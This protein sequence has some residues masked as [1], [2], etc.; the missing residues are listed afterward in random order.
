MALYDREGKILLM[1]KSGAANLGG[2]PENFVGKSIL[3]LFPKTGN[4]YLERINKAFRTSSSEEYEDEV[5]FPPGKRW[6]ASV[7]QPVAGLDDEIFA[8]LIMSVDITPRKKAK[9]ALWESEE[10]YRDLYYE[11]PM[12]Y[13]ELDRDG[14]ITKVNRRELEMLGYNAEELI[15]QPVWKFVVEED[16]QESIMGKITDES[17]VS[18]GRD[19]N[20]RRKDGTTLPVLVDDR[21]VRDSDGRITGI[22]STIQDITELKQAEKAQRES[23]KKYRLFVE[24]ANDAIFVVQDGRTPFANQRSEDLLGYTLDELKEV[25]I[26]EW[27]HPADREMALDR[28]RRKLKGEDPPTDYTFR[29]IRRGSETRWVL[30]NCVLIE[31][32]ERPA[33][34]TFMRDITEQKQVEVQLQQAQKM[35]ALGAM[36][37]GLAHEINNPVNCI[38][39]NAPLIERIWEDILP[40]VQDYAEKNSEKTYG[41]LTFLFL[42]ENFAQ[43]ISDMGLAG[44]RI[45]KLVAALKN[46]VRQP[47]EI[48]KE[49]VDIN[50]VVENALQLS[51]ST[52]AKSGIEL[53]VQYGQNL[54][55]IEGHL[56]SLEQIFLNLVLNSVQA[57]HHEKGEIRITTS[58]QDNTK[59]ISIFVEDNGEGIDSA[60]ASNIFDPFFTTK[61][62]EGGGGLGL[63]VTYNL[64]KEFNGDI[65][66]ESRKDAGTVFRI[67]FPVEKSEKMARILIVDDDEQIVSLLSKVLARHPLYIVEA[68]YNGIEGLIK[69]GTFEP[70]VL[71]LDVSMPDMDGIEVCRKLRNDLSLSAVSVIIITGH[72]NNPRLREL[73]EMGFHEIYAKPF[74]T[75]DIM[76]AVSEAL[77]RRK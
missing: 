35:E 5:D 45:A 11:A 68:A 43:L 6:V 10:K 59:K 49:P 13:H 71:I 29:V 76:N 41:G 21:I 33:I 19:R 2:S 53:H 54:P 46:F 65:T 52:V 63:F 69:M 51:R 60:I 75:D 31:W 18:K 50:Q 4:V 37:A 61:H 44:D 32:E 25:P 73:K 58:F 55:M 12:G 16:E 47:E 15:G 39:I 74:A 77:I 42:K 36:A 14:C 38:L 24:N 27:I 56:E 67:A 22:R 34:L 3:D 57:I 1:N 9:Q 23:E 30:I 17:P 72:V 66:F 8:V 40:G 70:D 62:M 20:Y 26:A 7:Y 48:H 28:Y 64:V